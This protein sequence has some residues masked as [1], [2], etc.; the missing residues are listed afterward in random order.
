MSFAAE[1]GTK[2]F[3]FFDGLRERLEARME[4][5]REYFQ[6]IKENSEI[7]FEFF[8]QRTVKNGFSTGKKG[9]N[10]RK[11]PVSTGCGKPLWKSMTDA[12]LGR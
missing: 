5:A 1:G 8:G 9:K 6:T 4:E 11:I 2:R 10:G 12:D 3:A 7:K